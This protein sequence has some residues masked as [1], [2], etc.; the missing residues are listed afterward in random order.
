M[1][2]VA[3]IGFTVYFELF[4]DGGEAKAEGR[5]MD[6][7]RGFRP[8]SRVSTWMAY[9]KVPKATQKAVFGRGLGVL[10]AMPFDSPRSQNQCMEVAFLWGMNRE[11][12]RN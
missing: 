3:Q 5:S 7:R 1:V 10:A 2:L 12:C 6:T 11:R 9:P 8:R 4:L